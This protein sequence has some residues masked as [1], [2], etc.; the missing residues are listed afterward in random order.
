[1]DLSLKLL[2][3]Y[4][5]L[6]CVIPAA[7]SSAQTREESAF[8]RFHRAYETVTLADKARDANLPLDAMTLYREARDVHARLAAEY[9]DW[10][11]EVMA[12]R[13]S[14]CNTQMENLYRRAQRS[15]KT[16]L[17]ALT[18]GKSEVTADLPEA[19]PTDTDASRSSALQSLLSDARHHIE[20][21]QS[22]QARALLMEGIRL[23]PDDQTVRLLLGIVQCQSGMYTD[24]TYIIEPLSE[25]TPDV[26]AVRLALGAAYFGTGQTE[27]A[28]GQVARAL[29]INPNLPEAH[30]NMAQIILSMEPVDIE[31]A[32]LHYLEAMK[33]GATPDKTMD[34]MLLPEE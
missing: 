15:G 9:P 28:E 25:E 17:Q 27:P 32:R 22:D 29:E 13:I 23:D 21:G 18:N 1:M 30:Y 26:A 31:K 11:P 7:S 20:Q 19:G 33:L 5:V 6:L 34:A 24:A 16:F 2:T 4:L 8:L 12:F 10:Q 14:H 3:L